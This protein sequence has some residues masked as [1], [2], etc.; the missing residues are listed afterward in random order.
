MAIVY[1]LSSGDYPRAHRKDQIRHFREGAGQSFIANEVVKLVTTAG[2]GDEIQLA[3]ATD[4]DGTNVGIAL[5]P[6]TGVEG[7]LIAC[8]MFDE[9]V[10]LVI[11]VASGQVL[12]AN[13]IG[14]DFGKVRDNTNNIWELDRT[15]VTQKLFHVV[16]FAPSPNSGAIGGFYAHGDTNG[17]YIVR[18]TPG[19]AA[20]LST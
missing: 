5:E 11:A 1:A 18:I 4:G 8:L 7:S 14:T 15:N 13:D 19:K 17:K 20:V 12:N 9:D 6:A 2:K 10:E 3:T 16:G